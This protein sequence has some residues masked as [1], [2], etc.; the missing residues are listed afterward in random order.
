MPAGALAGWW[1]EGGVG[2][3]AWPGRKVGI[4]AGSG[5]AGAESILTSDSALLHPSTCATA[6]DTTRLLQRGDCLIGGSRFRI[7]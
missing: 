5:R 4:R 2:E 6:A 3:K 7:L 1:G